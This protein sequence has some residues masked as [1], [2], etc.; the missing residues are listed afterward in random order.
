MTV[1]YDIK[2]EKEQAYVM[3]RFQKAIKEKKD[4]PYILSIQEYIFNK[5][6]SGDYKYNA[7]KKQFIPK[8]KEYSFLLMNKLMFENK[9]N[10]LSVDENYCNKMGELLEIDKE[11]D[12]LRYN[13]LCCEVKYNELGDPAN[14]KATQNAINE[15]YTTKIDR[16]AL[17]M[18][19]LKYQFR[20]V[21][22]L[23]TLG[24][25]I[26]NPAIIAAADKI[27]SILKIDDTDWKSALKLANT[28]IKQQQDYKYAVKILE[29]F[30]Y[31]DKTD[32][33]L[34]FTYISLCSLFPEKL[35]SDVFATAMQKASVENP[36]RFCKLFD[37][38]KL[39]VQT[40]ENLK[41]KEIYCSDC[42]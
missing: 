23:D 13:K 20:I 30:I 25:D 5:V 9:Y 12:F 41:V 7:V 2:G 10:N 19:N 40:F 24:E 8:E 39:S 33:E 35:Y 28:V 18:L 29:P 21:E 27:R 26:E 3:S 16:S 34:L 31:K 22:E 38:S 14:I 42:K 36:E 11:N 37:G 17:D 6:K 15:L 1:V 32:E 4:I